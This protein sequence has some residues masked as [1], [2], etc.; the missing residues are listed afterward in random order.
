MKTSVNA[1]PLLKKAEVAA[2]LNLTVR[3]VEDMMRRRKIPFLR[4]SHKVVRFDLDKVRAALSKFEVQAV[5]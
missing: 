1:K 4:M 5:D 3:G 2:E